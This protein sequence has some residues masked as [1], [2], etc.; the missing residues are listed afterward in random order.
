[1]SMTS[2]DEVSSDEV[3]SDE[4][5]SD[6]AAKPYK[7]P[8]FVVCVVA[9]LLSWAFMPAYTE[10]VDAWSYGLRVT[11]RVAFVFLM[12]AYIARPLRQLFGRG[13]V[14]VVHRRY[15]GLAMALAH[16][17]HFV[18]VYVVVSQYDSPLELP[19]LLGGGL[20]FVLMWLMAAT[21]NNQ[22]NTNARPPV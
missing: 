15:L 4:V 9:M 22:I 8:I 13:R 11:A 6:L 12:L 16:T 7:W 17:V 2:T 10:A 3:S 18:C 19:I 14:L 20:A 21:S 1:M 5:K